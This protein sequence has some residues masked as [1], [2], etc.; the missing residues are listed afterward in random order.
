MKAESLHLY[1]LN[2]V[3]WIVGSVTGFP[4]ECERLHGL[5]PAERAD[6]S[7]QNLLHCTKYQREGSSPVG[8]L[9]IL[10]FLSP[11]LRLFTVWWILFGS[12]GSG[13]GPGPGSPAPDVW[14]PEN[15]P[16]LNPE[17]LNKCWPPS[18]WES[19]HMYPWK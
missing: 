16:E 5:I 8:S 6:P 10:P 17:S 1:L 19:F 13:P 7:P 11:F 14:R 15:D 18:I 4:H 3:L 2:E 12:V 9:G